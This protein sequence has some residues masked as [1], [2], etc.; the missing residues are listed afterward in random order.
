[1]PWNRVRQDERQA[2]ERR[3][4]ELVGLFDIVILPGHR[5][6]VCERGGPVRV[7]GERFL[8]RNQQLRGLRLDA[9]VADDQTAESRNRVAERLVAVD[10][11]R[12]IGCAIAQR[13]REPVVAQHSRDGDAGIPDAHA[14]AHAEAELIRIRHLQ[15]VVDHVDLLAGVG[16]DE[17]PMQGRKAVHVLRIPCDAGW[18]GRAGPLGH[19]EENR[20]HGQRG[21]RV[22]ELQEVV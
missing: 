11:E 14:I 10:E 1:M 8:R 19:V 17:E 22:L 4:I 12:S 9:I 16:A 2:A 13:E 21:L 3:P 7:F 18:R 20:V 6:R 5:V 15:P